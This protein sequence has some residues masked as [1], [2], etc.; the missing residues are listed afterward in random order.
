MQQWTTIKLCSNAF[1]IAAAI[2]IIT[3]AIPAMVHECKRHSVMQGERDY[4]AIEGSTGP[5]VYPAGF[6]YA[7]SILFRLSKLGEIG[8]AQIIFACLYLINQVIH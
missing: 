4:K 2:V 1:Q 3:I 8:A 5:V 7:Y 6:L